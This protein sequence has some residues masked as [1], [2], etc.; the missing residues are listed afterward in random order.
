MVPLTEPSFVSIVIVEDTLKKQ[1]R[2]IKMTFNFIL[3]SLTSV[4]N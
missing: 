4:H 3:L 2:K 1:N